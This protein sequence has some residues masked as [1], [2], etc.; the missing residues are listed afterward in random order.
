MVSECDPAY[1]RGGHTGYAYTV[2][3]PCARVSRGGKT[4]I[5]ADQE[6]GKGSDAGRRVP[7]I[8]ACSCRTHVN[9]EA[10]RVLVGISGCAGGKRNDHAVLQVHGRRDQPVADGCWIRIL[11]VVVIGGNVIVGLSVVSAE[12]SS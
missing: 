3:G 7:D 9:L 10:V 2:N 8:A 12:C 5:Y 11:C 4:R 6:V 1:G